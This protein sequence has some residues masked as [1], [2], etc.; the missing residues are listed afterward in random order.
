MM[1]TD[2]R[3]LILVGEL[4]RRSPEFPR[5]EEDWHPD[6]PYVA[7]GAFARY[8]CNKIRSGA[9]DEL[10]ERAFSLLNE[11]A[12][13]NDMDELNLL[14][15]GVLEI[16]MDDPQCSAVAEQRLNE[17]GRDSLRRIREAWNGPAS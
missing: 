3:T 6:L 13:S 10:L 7:F 11:M 4:V 2:K 12:S 17:F 5:E 1:T 16:I 15:V 8:L 14:E 9:T